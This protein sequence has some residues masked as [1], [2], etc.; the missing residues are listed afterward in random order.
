[1]IGREIFHSGLIGPDGITQNGIPR[2]V[3]FVNGTMVTIA[4]ADFLNSLFKL[5]TNIII[6]VF[7]ALL[8]SSG[9]MLLDRNKRN[10]LSYFTIGGVIIAGAAIGR[11]FK[12]SYVK[13][14]ME[15]Y[16][17]CLTYDRELENYKRG[18]GLAVM[19]GILL[20]CS[21]LFYVLHRF[22]RV[23]SSIAII[24]GILLIIACVNKVYI[25]KLSVGVFLA[26]SLVILVEICGKRLSKNSNAVD[27]SIATIYLVPICLL[28][29]VLAVL[30]PSKPEPIQWKGVKHVISVVREQSSIWMTELRYRFDKSSG[31]FEVSF[32]DYSDNNEG[33]LGGDIKTSKKNTLIVTTDEKSTSRGY[34][35]G[36]ISDTYTGRKWTKSDPDT[37]DYRNEDYYLDF[38]ELLRAFTRAHEDGLDLSGMVE[39]RSFE[40]EYRDI[41]TRSVFYPLKTYKIYFDKPVKYKETPQGALVYN[42]AKGNGSK[43]N[44]QYYELNLNSDTLKMLLRNA[45][46]KEYTVTEEALRRV[47]EEVFGYNTTGF[48]IDMSG[49]NQDLEVRAD[50]IMKQYT[51][52]P[53]TLPERVRQLA[54]DITGN[55]NNDYDK[56]KAIEDYL[57]R[58]DY[59]TVISSTPKKEDFV[60][61]FLFEQQKGYCTYFASAMG[62]LA[63]C[64]GIP[65]RYVEGFM[66]DYKEQA[67]AYSYKVFSKNAHSWI[68]AYIE[69]VGWIPFEPTPAFYQGRYTE[70]QN[71]NSS[72]IYHDSGVNLDDIIATPPVHQEFPEQGKKAVPEK[73]IMAGEY[74]AAVLLMLA[75]ALLLFGAALYLYYKF[76]ENRH[77]RKFRNASD[78]TKLSMQISEILHYLSKD[79]YRMTSDDTLYRYAKRIGNAVNFDNISF[80][81]IVRIFMRVRYGDKE[82]QGRELQTVIKFCKELEKY[83]YV[84]L[85]KRKMFFDRFVFLHLN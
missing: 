22:K 38:Y 82:P 14:V 70:W 20:L 31:E 33:E 18:Y 11:I 1:M 13:A 76:L 73:K 59:T 6:T 81:E 42:K 19:A 57:N 69:G 41:M 66:V 35:T 30:L 34:L 50:E 47:G 48:D 55:C 52:L 79:G 51:T 28:L 54:A 60:D 16:N 74:I 49:L 37:V 10:I 56:L 67:G 36:S 4:L 15:V 68:E 78:R 39:K 5:H 17:W 85:G 71:T 23:K 72:G 24:S 64:E 32:S 21:I 12:F 45:G 40:I 53:D 44:V 3:S 8:F 9:I 62:I 61:Y 29:A 26:Y 58:M 75:G 84:K 2:G 77:Y 83:M 25:P 46:Q 63:R 65:T 7:A 80:P 43:Y 27:N